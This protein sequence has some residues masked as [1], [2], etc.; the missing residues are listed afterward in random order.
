MRRLLSHAFSEA[1]LREQEPLL[2]TYFDLLI[3]KLY[4]KVQGPAQGEVDIVRWFNFTTFDLVGDLCF[5]ES[6][7]AL[8]NEEYHS[9]IAQIFQGLKFVRMFKVMRAYPLIGYPILA[10]IRLFP[11]LS[12]ARHKHAQYTIEKTA[13]RLDLHTAR[14]DF[15]RYGSTLVKQHEG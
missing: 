5:G 8:Q 7:N 1:A 11:S 2:N 14:K 3:R 4:E 13:R 10:M 9:W 12:K 15:M 6:F